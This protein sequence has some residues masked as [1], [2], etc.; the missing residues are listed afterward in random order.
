MDN[1]QPNVVQ[2]TVGQFFN[3]QKYIVNYV[4]LKITE[5]GYSYYKYISKGSISF[6]DSLLTG[7]NNILEKF[8]NYSSLSVD[9]VNFLKT[10]KIKMF[11]VRHYFIF[12]LAINLKM[13]F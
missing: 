10:P 8:N 2:S 7:L 3:F 11:Y 5:G 13:N 12:F 4:S 6:F 1:Y 9:D